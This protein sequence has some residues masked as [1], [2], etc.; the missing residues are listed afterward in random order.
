VEFLFRNNWAIA[1]C[2]RTLEFRND[3]A[4]RRVTEQG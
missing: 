4:F 2:I 1:Y 3:K